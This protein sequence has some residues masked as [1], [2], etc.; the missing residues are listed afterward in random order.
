MHSKISTGSY[1]NNLGPFVV[2]YGSDLDHYWAVPVMIMELQWALTELIFGPSM[3]CH[4]KDFGPSV[5]CYGSDFG[6]L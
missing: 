1:R 6:P 3:F 4:K 5:I 2:S